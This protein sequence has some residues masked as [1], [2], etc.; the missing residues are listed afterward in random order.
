MVEYYVKGYIGLFIYLCIDFRIC[1]VW[2]SRRR[3]S[4]IVRCYVGLVKVY[5][6]L[7]F[8]SEVL[9]FFKGVDK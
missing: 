3:V 2:K 6:V 8:L 4:F 5:G 7:L 1:R 9:F